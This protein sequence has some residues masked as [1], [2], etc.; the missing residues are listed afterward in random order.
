[1]ASLGTWNRYFVKDTAAS[2]VVVCHGSF[3]DHG[4]TTTASP[5][6]VH[7]YVLHGDSMYTVEILQILDYKSE[8]RFDHGIERNL[9][10][11]EAVAIMGPGSFCWNYWLCAWDQENTN[12]FISKWETGI[13]DTCDLL[14]LPAGTGGFFTNPPN[15]YINQLFQEIAGSG[16]QY[17]KIHVCACRSEKGQRKRKEVKTTV[18]VYKVSNPYWPHN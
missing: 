5:A 11:R 2:A 9:P 7:F 1:M 17:D 16:K 4:F 14:M 13:S 15:T 12:T 10:R 3:D 8:L 18:E 6:E